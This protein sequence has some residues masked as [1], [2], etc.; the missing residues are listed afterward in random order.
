[1]SPK[2]IIDETKCTGCVTCTD[3]CP[4]QVFKLDNKKAKV[5][6]EK[7]CIGCRACEVQCEAECIKVSD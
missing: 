5:V 1:M 2:P 6:N 3:I 4:M 7:D